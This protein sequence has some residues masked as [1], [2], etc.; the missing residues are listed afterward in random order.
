[1]SKSIFVQTLYGN[2]TV[3][4]T[5]RLSLGADVG[6]AAEVM[7]TALTAAPLQTAFGQGALPLGVVVS[8]AV[9][10]MIGFAFNRVGSDQLFL[11][12]DGHPVA[13]VVFSIP[14]TAG[15]VIRSTEDISVN[16]FIAG[17]ATGVAIAQ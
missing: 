9:D 17:V 11:T 16:S 6:A 1:M 8:A 10:E 3:T 2:P 5:V 4:G 15:T 13:G 14:S 12:L 7:S